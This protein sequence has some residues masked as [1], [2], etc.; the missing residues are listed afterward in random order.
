MEQTTAVLYVYSVSTLPVECLIELLVS[1]VELRPSLGNS[2]HV[3]V[4]LNA[5]SATRCISGNT[6]VS[7]SRCPVSLSVYA[8]VVNFKK[9][10][11]NLSLSELTVQ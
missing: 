11:T 4:L 10:L 6:V 7:L 3:S 8:I 1:M 2:S 5:Y 9:V